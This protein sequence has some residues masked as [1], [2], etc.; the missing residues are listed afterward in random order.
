M[1]PVGLRNTRISTDDA[2]KSPPDTGADNGKEER[3]SLEADPTDSISEVGVAMVYSLVCV[4][5]IS[6]AGVY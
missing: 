4:C 2:Q 6:T 3:A 1:Q 5:E